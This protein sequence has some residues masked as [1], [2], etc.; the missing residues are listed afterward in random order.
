SFPWR[1]LIII[2][3]DKGLLENE[4]VDK[5][6]TPNVLQNTSWTK[7]GKV[8]WD[9]WYANNMYNVDFRAGINTA[10]YIYYVDFA[11]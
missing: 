1:T 6:S 3:D 5:L 10:T 9:W 8:S 7:P 2:P 11:A 4:L